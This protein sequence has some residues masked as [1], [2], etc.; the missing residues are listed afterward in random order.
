MCATDD[1]DLSHLY[2][3]LPLS[4]AQTHLHTGET[5]PHCSTPRCNNL[6]VCEVQKLRKAT[7]NFQRTHLFSAGLISRNGLYN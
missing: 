4:I 1:E 6:Q 2:K 3:I 7:I 5:L